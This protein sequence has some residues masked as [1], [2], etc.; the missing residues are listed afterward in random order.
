MVLTA[1]KRLKRW[2]IERHVVSY[3]I[4]A[5]NATGVAFAIRQF[6]LEH[7]QEQRRRQDREAFA[8]LDRAAAFSNARLPERA[9]IELEA[10]RWR[11]EAEERARVQ[12]W[13]W[14]TSEG[15]ER[16]WAD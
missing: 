3:T 1:A 15:R 4:I 16:P 9:V 12:R 13:W 14:L 7:E 5:A 11:L 10:Y 6:V 8:A 2:F